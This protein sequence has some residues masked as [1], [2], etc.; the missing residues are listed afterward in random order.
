MDFEKSLQEK[1]G[2]KDPG[3]FES[4]KVESKA[5]GEKNGIQKTPKG[6]ASKYQNTGET[7]PSG[8]AEDILEVAGKIE[9][10]IMRDREK[11]G[12][13]EKFYELIRDYFLSHGAHEEKDWAKELSDLSYKNK[14]ILVRRENPKKIFQFLGGDEDFSVGFSDQYGK[15]PNAALLGNDMSGL[16]L[17]LAGG[18]GKL[19]KGSAVFTVG[20]KPSPQMEVGDIPAGE[21]VNFSG[22]DRKLVKMVDGK[23]PPENVEFVLLR[24][25]RTLFPEKHMTDW[26]I[27]N[28]GT[29]SIQRMFVIDKKRTGHLNQ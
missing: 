23:T 11:E 27:E 25:P 6:E 7:P 22:S 5:P 9:L 16:R 3:I 13:K 15:E 17:A 21:Y 29:H 8:S 1:Q 28:E 14:N 24:I 20:F 18:F 2:P 26:E 10:A 12:N 19:G 4:E